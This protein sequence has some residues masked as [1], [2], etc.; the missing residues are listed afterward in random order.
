MARGELWRRCVGTARSHGDA[1]STWPREFAMNDPVEKPAFSRSILS[2]AIAGALAAAGSPA[3]AQN[4]Q[5]AAEEVVGLE[6]VI[7]TARFKEEKLQETP[8]AITALTADDIQGRA[9]QNAYEV[10]Y[11]VPNAS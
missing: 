8:I 10:A 11:S 5:P 6:E 4:A 9:M 1:I 3:G 7:V 2:L